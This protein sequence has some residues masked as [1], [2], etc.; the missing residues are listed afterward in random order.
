MTEPALDPQPRYGELAGRV[1][2]VTGAAKGIGW[3]IS[4][5]LAAEGMKL[6]AADM[7]EEALAGS[8]AVLIEAGTHVHLFAGDIASS[9]EVDRL[10]AE[11]VAEFGGVDLLVNNAADLSRVRMLDDHDALL[12]LQMA[13]NVLGPYKCSQRAAAL[14]REAGG[15][16]IVHISSV[17][18][19]QAHYRG[20]PYDVTKGAIDALTRAMA[21]DLGIYGIRVNAVA[22]GVTFTYRTEPYRDAPL[23]LEALKGIP[24]QRSGTIQDIAA[25][26]AFLASDEAS[27]ITGQ[28]LYVDGG[29]TAQLAPPGP[30]ELE[31]AAMG[32]SSHTARG[33]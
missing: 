23:Y 3:G 7:D 18:G 22:P 33:I 24:L 17:G 2:V 1:A 8:S 4:Q 5:R 31:D 32:S 30:G 13:T 16:N 14:M 21:I 11:A 26:V 29:I 12:D 25:A 27:Y 28:V 9:E 6:V 10:F 20:L 19:I 15:G